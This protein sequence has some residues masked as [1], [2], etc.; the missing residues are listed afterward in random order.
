MIGLSSVISM[1]VIW[2]VLDGKAGHRNQVIGLTDALQRQVSVQCHDV[3]VTSHLRGLRFLLPG[4]AIEVSDLPAPD[5]LIGAGHATHVPL[6][7][8]RQRFSG[9]AIVLMKPTIPMAAFD[10]N[11]VASNQNL[12]SVPPNVILT[13]GPLNRMQPSKSSSDSEGLILI[14]G[15]SDHFVWSDQKILRQLA[16]IL[17]ASDGIHWTLTTSRRTPASFLKAW[18]TAGLP[19]DMVPSEATSPD[20]ILPRMQRAGCVWVSCDSQSMIF[21]ALTAGAAVGVLE[22]PERRHSRDCR[23]VQQMIR[24]G[25]VAT[26][27]AWADGNPLKRMSVPLR[28]ADRCAAEVINRFLIDHLPQSRAA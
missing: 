17:A 26:W 25:N 12:R 27:S 18:S 10:L 2:R 13:E 1:P 21:E 11:I 5:L 9:R 23:S 24:N 7:A 3:C 22:L 6:L 14:G 4:N 16:D 20:W 19:G 15:P 8:L 28:E